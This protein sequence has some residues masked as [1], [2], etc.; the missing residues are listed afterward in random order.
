MTLVQKVKAYVANQKWVRHILLAWVNFFYDTRFD[1]QRNIPHLPIFRAV[2][3]KKIYSLHFPYH[4]KAVVVDIGAHAG[5]FSIYAAKN[6]HGESKIFA[7]EPATENFML[8]K[9]N[10]QSHGIYNIELTKGA[11]SASTGQRTLILSNPQNHSLY[12]VYANSNEN[13]EEV[14][15]YSLKDFMVVREIT[16]I[17]F[18]KIDCEGSEYE[19]LLHTPIDILEKIE[20]VSIEIHDMR[21]YGY[22]P[23]RL[24]NFMSDAGFQME[25]PEN[26]PVWRPHFNLQVVWK[27]KS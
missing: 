4:K 19:I 27:R 17:D 18:L 14:D 26:Y 16:H 25:F 21:Q 5:Y 6:L 1:P 24:C 10:I 15:S 11:I 7:I 8:M 9:H 22:T 12:D 23:K 3:Y 2:F 20:V 13:E